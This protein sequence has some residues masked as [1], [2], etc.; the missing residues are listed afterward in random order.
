MVLDFSQNGISVIFEIT[1]KKKVAL[2]NFAYEGVCCC[3]EKPIKWRPALELHI[4]GGNQDDHHGAKHTGTSGFFSLCYEEH[5]YYENEYGNKLELSLCDDKLRTIINYQFYKDLSLVRTWTTVENILSEDV[6][7]EYVSSFA[8][9]GLSEDSPRVRIPHSSWKREA[10]W[11]DYS[12]EE[13][14]LDRNCDFSMN[15][16]TAS[17]TGM[18]SC[19]EYLPM[20]AYY[21][22]KST[23]MWQIESNGS[24][25]WEI[26]DIADMLYLRLSGPTEQENQWH[27]EL[28]PGEV[29]ESVKTALSFGADFDSALETMT[30]YRRIL[31]QNSETNKKMPIIFNDYMHCLWAD[32]TTEKMLPVIDKAA[33]VGAEYYCMDAGWY[34]DGTWWETVGEWLP[35]EKRFPKG[36]NE[37]FDHIRS[38]RMVPG[39][40]LELE[41][42]GI[43][44]P[45]AEKFEDECFFM[46]HGRRVIDHG[47]YQLDFRN[48]KVR[49]YTTS[50]VDRVVQEYG[51]GYIKSDYNIEGGVGTEVNADSFGDGLLENNR[52]YLEWIDEIRAKYPDLVLE[53]C[54]SGGLRMDYAH[55]EKHHLLSVSDQIDWRHTA[56][57]AAAIPTAVLPEQALIWTYPRKENSENAVVFNM[58]NAMLQRMNLSGEITALDERQFALVKEGVECYKRIRNDIANFVPFY[59]MEIPKYGDGW[60][61][62]GMKTNERR[63][64][65]VWRM[66]SKENELE[67]PLDFEVEDVKIFYPSSADC[68]VSKIHGGIKVSLPGTYTAVILEV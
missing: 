43:G 68:A 5:K 25:Q 11:K 40:W 32:P 24:W 58:V 30:K 2:K 50:I 20:G 49:D 51:V 67:I 62:L 44:C 21:D 34:A 4:S 55:L 65:A 47:R 13:L 45:L 37:V 41:V 48:K 53:G 6:G 35:Q 12:I 14:G 3:E 31:F 63:M 52:A 66:D 16:I 38:K 33:E 59:P 17:N 22:E 15:R 46:R 64:L 1:D 18:W 19:K 39:I 60:L 26:G 42:M 8:Y 27:K 10:N 61:C 29:F 7:L 28:K 56:N 57:I 9:T 23:L 36:I 54:S